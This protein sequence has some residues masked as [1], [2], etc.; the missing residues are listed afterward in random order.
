MST[1]RY[2][3]QFTRSARRGRLC[4]CFQVGEAVSV[5]SE[6]IRYAARGPCQL[7]FAAPP[8]PAPPIRPIL[9]LP[10]DLSAHAFLRPTH[11]YHTSIPFH[12]CVTVQACCNTVRRVATLAG[13]YI[14][15]NAGHGLDSARV[16]GEGR[17]RR[18]VRRVQKSVAPHPPL[19]RL[20]PP[21]TRMRRSRDLPAVASAD[22]TYAHLRRSHQNECS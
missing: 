5:V 16:L 14:C 2:P 6:S 4:V 13:K 8:Y 9:P 7:V 21:D 3:L 15:C 12:P 11:S 10:C 22:S 20:R 1:A 18:S 19:P 17:A